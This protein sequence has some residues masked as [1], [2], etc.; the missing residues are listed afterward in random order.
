[1]KSRTRYIVPSVFVLF[2]VLLAMPGMAQP[3]CITFEPPPFVLGTTYGAPVGQVSGDLAFV[4]SGISG[5]VYKFSQVGG[6]T[7][8]SRAF[9]DTAPVSFSP[10]Q[11]LRFNNI[12]LQFDFSGVG[13][14]VK[15]VT[16][17]YLDLGGYENLAINGSSVYVGELTAAPAILGGVNVA[18]TSTPVPPPTLG[19]MGT[20][21]LKGAVRTLRIGGQEFWIDSVCAQ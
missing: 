17:S 9:I 19:K 1:M 18:V 8:F 12:D 13:F 2:A 6:G 16:L 10:G 14:S 21:T 20:V 4:T 5:F 7:A 11:S 3:V 15:K